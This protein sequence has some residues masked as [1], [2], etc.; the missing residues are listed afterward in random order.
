MHKSEWIKDAQNVPVGQSRRVY[1]GAETRP[2]L[3]VYNNPD[4]YS[5]WCH[6]CQESGYVPKEV[7]Q[8]VDTSAP[9]FHKYLCAADCMTLPELSVAHPEKFKR[10]VL[11]LHR[12]HMSTALLAPYKPV[13]N[14][15]DDRLVFT[16]KGA[17]VGR[18]CTEKSHAKWLH[19]HNSAEPLDFLYLQGKK[20]DCIREPIVLV[21]DLFS[22]IKVHKYT[23]L[24]T[25][26]CK[27]THISDDI[28]A[29]LTYPRALGDFF[30]PVL[31]FDGDTAGYKAT[32]TAHKRLEIRGV[33]HSIVNVPE[34]CD[35][36]DL[37]HI[38]LN[39]LF[40]GVT[41]GTIR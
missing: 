4:C 3:V 38:E 13:Y 6:S 30:Y 39:E 11:L 14:V 2:N 40:Q 36:K 5:A 33:E 10:M 24:S 21:E 37:S 7:L 28:I 22:A 19:Y 27:G 17:S 31:A 12:K 1:H 26:W 16:F 8:R 23:G 15:V 32:R 18:D 35:P 41:N 34:G 25:M 9:V 29:F 20:A